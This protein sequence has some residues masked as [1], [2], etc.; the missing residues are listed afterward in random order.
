M[1]RV[2]DDRKASYVARA[3]CWLFTSRIY[4]PKVPHRLHV[5]CQ[6]GMILGDC[7][8]GAV[9]P[10]P[11]HTRIRSH[12]T[13]PAF[14][15]T[16]H[17]TEILPLDCR[18]V[19][20]IHQCYTT[21][22][23]DKSTSERSCNLYESTEHVRCCVNEIVEEPHG[24]YTGYSKEDKFY[25]LLSPPSRTLYFTIGRRIT[26]PLH[27]S[28]SSMS[29]TTHCTFLYASGRS[30]MRRLLSRHITSE[31]NVVVVSEDLLIFVPMCRACRPY[32]RPAP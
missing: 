32:R 28:L 19:W 29:S 18:T 15:I 21:Y 24:H 22:T 17:H 1:Q 8:Q 3:S 13:Y 16:H 25:F 11:S 30:S 10:S 23:K 7:R 20:T 26:T 14:S 6:V 31:P 2:V 27:I 5:N 9:N 12:V 4:L